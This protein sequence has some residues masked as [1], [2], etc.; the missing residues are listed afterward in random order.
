M[1]AR[2]CHFKKGNSEDE[3]NMY[4]LLQNYRPALG[5]DWE[6]AKEYIDFYCF[7]GVCYNIISK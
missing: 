6:S 7:Q 4:Y 3:N 5:K 1:Q 2:H